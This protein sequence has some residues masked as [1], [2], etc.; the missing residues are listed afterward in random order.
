[1]VREPAPFTHAFNPAPKGDFDKLAAY[2]AWV[3]TFACFECGTPPPSVCCHANEGKGQSLKVS[4]RRTFPL[5]VRCHE[6]LDQSK[7]MVREE[8]R[9]RERRYVARMQEIAR[10]AKRPEFN[11]RPGVLS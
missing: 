9:Q 4:D 7:G 1:L 10:N 8:R 3:K 2:R 5:C 6:I 11:D